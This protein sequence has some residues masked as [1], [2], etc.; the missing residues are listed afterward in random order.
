MATPKKRLV[1]DY[2]ALPE[3]IIRALKIKYP[4]G[5][6]DHLISYIDA[7]GKK[8]SALP[9]EAEDAHY[10]VRMTIIE[11]K[12][13]VKEDDDFDDE[14]ILR[15]GFAGVDAPDVAD[16]EVEGTEE[17]HEEFHDDNGEDDHII[18]TRRN[19]DDDDASDMADDY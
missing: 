19:D 3:E 4:T 18:V 14:G 6:E 11:A 9:F 16:D 12:R 2:D 5:Y 17:D 7:K 1:K 10:L 8:V 13:L 15:E